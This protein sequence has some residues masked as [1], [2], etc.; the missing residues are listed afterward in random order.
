[1][2]LLS[3]RSSAGGTKLFMVGSALFSSSRGCVML[4]VTPAVNSSG[5]RLFLSVL[6]GKS[7]KNSRIPLW[8]EAYRSVTQPRASH[9]EVPAGGARKRRSMQIAHLSICVRNPRVRSLGQ[10]TG[11]RSILRGTAARTLPCTPDNRPPSSQGKK[12]SCSSPSAQ[13]TSQKTPNR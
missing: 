4:V 1:M 3:S 12:E 7:C 6:P 9:I 13:G 5:S 11:S 8:L 2:Y 10:T